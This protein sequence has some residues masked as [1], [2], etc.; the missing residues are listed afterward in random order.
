MP[1]ER[2]VGDVAVDY[3]IARDPAMRDI[4]RRGVATAEANFAW[5]V[6]ADITGLQPGRP[7]WYRFTLGN[8][9]SPLGRTRTAP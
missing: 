8:K 1:I 3:E 5:S 4:V 6:H 7:Y 2:V 9:A